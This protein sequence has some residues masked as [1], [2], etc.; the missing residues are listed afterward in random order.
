M[1][2]LLAAAAVAAQ[3]PADRC[4]ARVLD[5]SGW[6]A[7]PDQSWD[8][9]WSSSEGGALTVIGAEHQRDPSHPQFAR[10]AA[11]FAEAAPDLV[12]FEGPDRGVGTDIEETIRTRGE[13]GYVR[14]LAQTR[15]AE[16]RSLEPSPGEQM[17]ALLAAHPIDQVNLFFVLREAARLRDREGAAGETLDRAV[18][19]L[20]ARSS[21]MARSAGLSLPVTDLASLDSSVRRY[22]PD[23]DWRALPAD[24]FS[25][26]ADDAVTG[27]L[28]LGTINRTDSMN[29]DRHMVRQLVAAA[30]AG[31]R[32]FVVVGRNHVPMQAPSLDC[33]LRG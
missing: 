20:I 3:A 14:F 6:R 29:R 19:A 1:L 5:Y 22:W 31:R 13:S 30:R 9:R 24:W 32:V 26:A 17:A 33:A 15:D 16:A 28:F 18:G 10:I 7:A 23:R 25:P 4:E 2:M 21:E 12:L 8:Y 27:G 11:A